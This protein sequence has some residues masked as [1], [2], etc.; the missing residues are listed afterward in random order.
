MCRISED[1]KAFFYLNN[2]IDVY[3]NKHPSL[4]S[5]TVSFVS[6]THEVSPLTNIRYVKDNPKAGIS[7]L[8]I[9]FRSMQTKTCDLAENGKHQDY[10]RCTCDRLSVYEHIILDILYNIH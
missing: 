4:I 6:V 1:E 7:S 3:F 2:S 10:T 9:S 8:L 5:G